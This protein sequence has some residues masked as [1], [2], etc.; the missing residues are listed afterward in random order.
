MKKVIFFV[1][2]CVLGLSFN[3]QALTTYKTAESVID[4][5]DAQ[6][7]WFVPDGYDPYPGDGVFGRNLPN[8]GGINPYYRGYN[9][10][11]GWTH[12]LNFDAIGPIEIVSATLTIEA[13]DVDDDNNQGIDRFK[14]NEIDMIKIGSGWGQ[15]DLGHLTGVASDW[16]TTTFT[17][18]AAQLAKISVSDQTGELNVFM[19]ISSLEAT[20]TY[21]Y[22]YW[23][24]TLKSATLTVD[25]IPAPGAIILGSFGAGLV[26]WLRK[27]KTL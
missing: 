14:P 3:V 10:D 6:P 18:D 23:Y 8:G 19:D 20:G 25:Y 17:F 7:Q 11:W 1:L 22:D 5:S 12:T 26:G 16:S 2:L 4:A 27:R 24:V 13:W 21:T 9:E 15:E